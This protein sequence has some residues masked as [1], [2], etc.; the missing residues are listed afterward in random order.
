M[1]FPVFVSRLSEEDLTKDRL[2]EIL[3][4]HLL[5]N[6]SEHIDKLARSLSK[7]LESMN[8]IPKDEVPIL[9]EKYRN[10][11]IKSAIPATKPLLEEENGHLVNPPTSIVFENVDDRLVATGVFSMGRV[12]PLQKKHLNVCVTNGWYFKTDDEEI[13][14][15]FK[16]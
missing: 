3:S 9:C 1:S 4:E 10:L 14:C 5:K 6:R 2:R 8:V 13:S 12:Y 15:P 7:K 16:I 11:I